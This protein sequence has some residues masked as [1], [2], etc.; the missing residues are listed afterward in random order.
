MDAALRQAGVIRC[1][2]IEEMFNNA[3]AL[4]YQPLSRLMFDFFQ[5]LPLDFGR[6]VMRDVALL[7]V[8]SGVGLGALGSYVSVRS[9][10]AR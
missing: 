2:T 3:I 6:F 8:G 1:Q 10:L 5:V 9:Y 4:A 7:V